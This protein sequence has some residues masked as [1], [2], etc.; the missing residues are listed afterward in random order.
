M[1]AYVLFCRL[2]KLRHRTLRKPN[3]IAVKPNINF[4]IPVLVFVY[5]NLRVLVFHIFQT[6]IPLLY[7]EK[8]EETKKKRDIFF[9]SLTIILSYGKLVLEIIG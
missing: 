5:N 4:D 9:E 3:R 2:K 6:I 8:T 7:H 1:L